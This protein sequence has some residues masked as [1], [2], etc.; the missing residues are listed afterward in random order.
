MGP[1]H[2]WVFPIKVYG[3]PF[4]SVNPDM[5][6]LVFDT[7]Q[8]LDWGSIVGNWDVWVLP[9]RYL[10]SLLISPLL[11]YSCLVRRWALGIFQ[12]T[13]KQRN[14]ESNFHII[15]YSSLHDFRHHTCFEFVV[16]THSTLVI[17]FGSVSCTLIN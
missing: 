6:N 12:F 11:V 3:T 14:Y 1:Q 4:G 9:R 8:L 2:L 7:C 16:I 10:A 5:F 13:I 15:I 17:E